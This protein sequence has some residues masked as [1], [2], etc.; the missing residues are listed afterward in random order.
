MELCKYLI[1]TYIESEIKIGDRHIKKRVDYYDQSFPP[2]LYPILPLPS[3]RAILHGFQSILL[4]QKAIKRQSLHA[5]KIF[6]HL[7][8]FHQDFY[9][10]VQRKGF[11]IKA[12]TRSFRYGQDFVVMSKSTLLTKI[13]FFHPQSS[14]MKSCHDQEEGF[15]N[16]PSRRSSAMLNLYLSSIFHSFFFS[17]STSRLSSDCQLG[18]MIALTDFQI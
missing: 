11:H 15:Y 17:I 9:S 8:R 2:L 13:S 18:Q 6:H 14:T 5:N 10:R 12:T 16:K 4:R 3:C 7:P 1:N